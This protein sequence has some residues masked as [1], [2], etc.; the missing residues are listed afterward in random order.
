MPKP[1]DRP[2]KKQPKYSS[3]SSPSPSRLTDTERTHSNKRTLEQREANRLDKYY[4][5]SAKADKQ[6]RQTD[7]GDSRRRAE[8]KQRRNNSNKSYYSQSAPKREQY[9]DTGT[10]RTAKRNYGT[11]QSTQRAMEE[12]YG[13]GR[14]KPSL[15]S[16]ADYTGRDLERK[17]N[18]KWKPSS[19]PSQRPGENLN[20]KKKSNAPVS[21]KEGEREWKNH[22]YIDKVRTKSGKIRYIYRTPSDSERK[23]N[24]KRVTDARTKN[25]EAAVRK[26]KES[27]SIKGRAQAFLKRLFG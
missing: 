14:S 20:L 22:K 12:K 13:N 2:K 27:K 5:Q 19:V 16:R 25:L 7:T 15:Y 21:E 11:K 6:R 26:E 3:K 18:R 23:A 9:T 8:L 10:N 24:Q 17:V 1:T 4:K